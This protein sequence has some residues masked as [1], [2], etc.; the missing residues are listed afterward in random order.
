MEH[1]EYKANTNDGSIDPKW[2]QNPGLNINTTDYKY[3]NGF[4]LVNIRVPV[5][6]Q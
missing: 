4:W 1:V 2:V 5:D 6:M 3:T